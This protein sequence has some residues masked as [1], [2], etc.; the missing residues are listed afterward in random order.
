MP[1]I[2]GATPVTVAPTNLARMGW[3]RVRA[4]ERF[5]RRI[6]AAGW[7]GWVSMIFLFGSTSMI[8]MGKEGRGKRFEGGKHTAIS[9]LARIST[10]AP[11]AIIRECRPD[12]RERLKCSPPPRSLVLTQ[13]DFF[14]FSTLRILDLGL[15]RHDLII[16]PSRLLRHLRSPITLRRESILRFPRDI[17]VLAHILRCLPHRLHAVCRFLG[18]QDGFVEGLS[19]AVAACGHKF[20]ADGEAAFDAAGRDLVGDVLHGFET[21]G[22][23]A[24]YGGGGSGVG[25]AGREGGGAD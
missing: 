6:A 23:E 1:I 22:A 20:C 5:I 7:M 15:D 18:F 16:E 25:E 2:R 24:V 12:L 19:E 3:W 13:C 8:G 14:L 11:V 9:D 4:V 17:E 10:G 21:R